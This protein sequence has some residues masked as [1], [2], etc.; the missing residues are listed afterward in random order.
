[1]H[2]TFAKNR[3]GEVAPVNDGASGSSPGRSGL[4]L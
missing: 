2:M 4:V 3:Y 1:M